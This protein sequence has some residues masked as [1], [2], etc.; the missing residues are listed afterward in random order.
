MSVSRIRHFS[1][2][3]S[4]HCWCEGARWGL[5]PLTVHLEAGGSFCFSHTVLWHTGIRSL[6]FSSYLTQTQA[7]VAADLK[8]ANTFIGAF[9]WVQHLLK[10]LAIPY[11]VTVQNIR[12]VDEFRVSLCNNVLLF[13]VVLVQ[14]KV[15]MLWRCC[16]GK[17]EWTHEESHP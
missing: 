9:T 8:S 5:I 2:E 7:V 14:S 11:S 16:A 6:I 10:V 17:L 3:G 12:A 15:T 13:Y 1:R 4:I